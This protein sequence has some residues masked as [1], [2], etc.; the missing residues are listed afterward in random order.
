MIFSEIFSVYY[1]TVAKILARAI[2]KPVT[3]SEME[4]II[5]ENAFSESVLEIM[6]AIKSSNWQLINKDGSTAIK[7]SPSIPLTDMEK[8][9]LKAVSM[10]KRIQ[11]FGA[12]FP[13]LE[14][15][16][17]LFTEDDFVFF[18]SYSDGDSFTDSAYIENFRLIMQA[19]KEQFPL[20]IHTLNKN[21]NTVKLTVMPDYLEYSEKNDKFRLVGK[22]GTVPFTVNLGRIVS[23]SR[24]SGEYRPAAAGSHNR[25]KYVTIELT[26]ERNALERVMLHFA[27]FEKQAEK[28]GE[29]TYR[30]T[31]RYDRDDETEILIRI[32][33]FG[34]FV[35]VTEPQ[36]FVDLMVNRLKR[37][38]KL[39]I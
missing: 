4:K 21:G 11:L 25:T 38:K 28:T 37:Q 26:D 17:P 36:K 32:L 2:E 39:N 1:S 35:K 31:I 19:I 5:A 10:D 18:D 27:H 20:E 13:A 9:W 30:L 22:G 16:T 33:G 8:R 23:C 15:V 6:P 3:D 12:E 24:Y 14:D 29:N 7:H 34:P